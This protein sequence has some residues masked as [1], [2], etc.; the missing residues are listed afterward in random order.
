MQSRH[1]ELSPIKKHKEQKDSQRTTH[2]RSKGRKHKPS[3]EE[4]EWSKIGTSK[5]TK[6]KQRIKM[7]QIGKELTVLSE[8]AVDMGHALDEQQDMIQ[9]VQVKMEDVDHKIN[10]KNRKIK[11]MLR[12]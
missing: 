4:K 8:R 5:E 3:E 9:D 6:T 7:V 10:R 12:K 1:K 2:F 11:S